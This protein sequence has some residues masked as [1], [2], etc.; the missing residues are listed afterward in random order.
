MVDLSWLIPILAILNLFLFLAWHFFTHK[1]DF[2]DLYSP[3]NDKILGV[4]VEDFYESV[5]KWASERKR[6]GRD[7]EL[8]E[9]MESL[10]SLFAKSKKL[11]VWNDHINRGSLL[12]K[13][14]ST[15]MALAG[16]LF[17]FAVMF[18]AFIFESE[19]SLALLLAFL[20]GY[21]AFYFMMQ[22]ARNW[23]EYCKI[24]SKIEENYTGLTL[25]KSAITELNEEEV[26]EG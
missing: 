16:V 13:E 9:L 18:Y 25:G 10:R 14:A 24:E 15:N 11:S 1:K 20:I 19:A 2:S 5:F 17:S 21:G 12:L 4:L 8:K 26:D 7:V 3:K 22:G 23:R 6:K